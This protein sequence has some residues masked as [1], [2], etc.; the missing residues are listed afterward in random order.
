M[1]F[2]G[3]GHTKHALTCESCAARE[4]GLLQLP[5]STELLDPFGKQHCILHSEKT[6]TGQHSTHAQALLSSAYCTPAWRYCSSTVEIG[7]FFFLLL[8]KRAAMAFI[9]SQELITHFGSRGWTAIWCVESSMVVADSAVA[10]AESVIAGFD[11]GGSVSG[12]RIFCSQCGCVTTPLG[13]DLAL[14]VTHLFVCT[15]QCC[16]SSVLLT[17]RAR[18][19]CRFI[20]LGVRFRPFGYPEPAPLQM[21]QALL[22][23]DIGQR[24]LKTVCLSE[25]IVSDFGRVEGNSGVVAGRAR[26]VRRCSASLI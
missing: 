16:R 12:G 13:Q 8:V 10:S 25:T 20:E 19:R 17:P 26:R 2:I 7:R 11:G 3:A 6:M 9:C 5:Y 18:R 21:I 15:L 23:F 14:D 1:A 24:I 22:Q 4:N